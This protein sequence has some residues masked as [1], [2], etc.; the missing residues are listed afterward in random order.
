M[1]YLELSLKTNPDN[2][3]EHQAFKKKM[4]TVSLYYGWKNDGSKPASEFITAFFEAQCK[5]L[6]IKRIED[7]LINSKKLLAM[8]VEQE[9]RIKSEAAHNLFGGDEL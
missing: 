1:I 3:E 4:E 5:T 7:A 6:L 9:S 8:Q 2:P